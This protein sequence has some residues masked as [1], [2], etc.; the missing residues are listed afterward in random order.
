MEQEPQISS[1]EHFRRSHRIIKFLASGSNGS[2]HLT[3]AR[4]DLDRIR[5]AYQCHGS[6]D[7]LCSNLRECLVVVKFYTPHSLDGF[8]LE[9]EVALL[10]MPVLRH[11]PQITSL[12]NFFREDTCQWMTM[13]YVPGSTLTALVKNCYQH[14]HLGL[15]WHIALQIANALLLFHW[16]ITDSEDMTPHS[17][18]YPKLTYMDMHGGKFLLGFDVV[19]SDFGRSWEYDESRPH[20]PDT[21]GRF[22]ACRRQDYEKL[23]CMMQKIFVTTKVGKVNSICKHCGCSTCRACPD[24]N[25]KGCF[26]VASGPSVRPQLSVEERQFLSWAKKLRRSVAETEEDLAA[27]LKQFTDVART[28]QRWDVPLIM[29]SEI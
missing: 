25:C 22:R 24:F 29:P 12:I 3:I 18:H 19:L 2:C 6:R 13:E 11:K 14:I 8:D 9:N 20:D 15:Q 23:G 21:P 1:E 4:D 26:R 7:K 10:E 27:L 28:Q 5:T 17:K 16:G